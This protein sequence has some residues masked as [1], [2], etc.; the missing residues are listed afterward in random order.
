MNEAKPKDHLGR[1]MMFKRNR[2][3]RSIRCSKENDP[4]D[5]SDF[6]AIHT[7][8]GEVNKLIPNSSKA[9]IC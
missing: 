4:G 2:E 5:T 3:G 9:P 7:A 1:I 8:L 6:P